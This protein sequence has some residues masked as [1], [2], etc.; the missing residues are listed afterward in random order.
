MEV[1]ENTVC[2]RMHMGMRA[3]KGKQ[4]GEKK[5]RWGEGMG[6]VGE[7]VTLRKP[8]AQRNRLQAWHP[9]LTGSFLKKEKGGRV[10]GFGGCKMSRKKYH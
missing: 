5:K 4:Q 10:G 1:K 6:R 8:E 2:G 3:R 7:S 9:S